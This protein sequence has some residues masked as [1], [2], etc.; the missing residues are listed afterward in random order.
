M[1]CSG[2]IAHNQGGIDSKFVLYNMG[3]EI[4]TIKIYYV[5]LR[6]SAYYQR[7]REIG[8]TIEF[9]ETF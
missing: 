2:L 1:D 4:L 9:R 7:G 3:V 5:A 8:T 6:Y